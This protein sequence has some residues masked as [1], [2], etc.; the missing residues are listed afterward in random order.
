VGGRWLTSRE[1]LQRFGERLTPQ[2]D[3]GQQPPRTAMRRRWAS[4]K[5]GDQLEALGI[6]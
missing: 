6:G 3:D 2:L 4:E 5:A 1:A